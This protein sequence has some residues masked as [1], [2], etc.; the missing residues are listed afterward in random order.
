MSMKMHRRGWSLGRKPGLMRAWA[1]ACVAILFTGVAAASDS[2]L[3]DRGYAH[4]REVISEVPWSIHILQIDRARADF[5]FHTTLPTPDT[6]GLKPL[7]DH[8]EAL[9]RELGRPIAA[10]NGDYYEN[11]NTSKYQGDPKGL[12]IMRGELIS[13]PSDWS[14]F[15]IDAHGAPHIGIVTSRFEAVWPDGTRTAFGLN[16]ERLR[17]EAVLYTP[18]VGRSTRT[19]GGRELVLE[20]GG[21]T[22]WL[23][24]RAGEDY[25]CRVVTVRE[26]GNTELQPH[27][28]VLSLSDDLARKVPRLKKG[29]F[30][31]L[32][33]ATTPSLK[34]V[35]TALGG[36]P[37]L[38]QNGRAGV[39]NFGLLDIRES[40]RHPRTALGWNDRYFFLVQVDGRQSGFSAGMTYAEL[41]SYMVKLGCT[42]AL[43]LDGGGSSTM[44]LLGQVVN[45]PSKGFERGMGNGLVLIQKESGLR[46]SIP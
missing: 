17:G 39:W 13:D 26:R 16:E 5:E 43:N 20:A 28:I 9:P 46:S 23:P 24:L 32:S 38:V 14:C 19:S 15:W 29:D 42:E 21:S 2:A 37:A 4:R 18:R 31:R 40:M 33:F 30:L 8:V 11:Q 22:F 7:R 1:P 3:A 10:V 44:W 45:S 25:N 12:H 36:G 41:A 35:E 6:I 27:Q 34:G